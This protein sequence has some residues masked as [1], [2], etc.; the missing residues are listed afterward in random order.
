M[1]L[2]ELRVKMYECFVMIAKTPKDDEVIE[3]YLT[4]MD[5]HQSILCRVSNRAYLED[6]IPEVTKPCG[7][8]NNIN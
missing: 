1:K 7:V 5:E 4:L 6:V 2:N 8:K 3:R